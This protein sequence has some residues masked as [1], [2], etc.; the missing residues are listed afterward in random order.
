MMNQTTSNQDSSDIYAIED[1]DHVTEIAVNHNCA[2]ERRFLVALLES[3]NDEIRGYKGVES[4]VSDVRQTVVE[5][6]N[7]KSNVR[8]ALRMIAELSES[9]KILS[10]AASY[11]YAI[12]EKWALTIFTLNNYSDI[13]ATANYFD[14]PCFESLRS[15]VDSFNI[16]TG[17]QVINSSNYFAKH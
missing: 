17:K 3:F 5:I 1:H 12:L 11:E 8:K 14:R 2:A 13:E 16:K 9:Q 4:E 10:S 7:K 6:F 15:L